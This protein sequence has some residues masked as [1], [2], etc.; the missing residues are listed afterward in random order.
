MDV[1]PLDILDAWFE[2]D[3]YKIL[4]EDA[5]SGKTA[6]ADL[7]DQINDQLYCLIFHLENNSPEYKIVNEIQF[8]KDLCNKFEIEF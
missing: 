5:D 3:V 2:S 1:D 6:S 4:C 8:F 7:L